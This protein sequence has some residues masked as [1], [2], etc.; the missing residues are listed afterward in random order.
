[1]LLSAPS[2]DLVRA[3]A[4][5][6]GASGRRDAEELAMDLRA[7]G[8]TVDTCHLQQVLEQ[9]DGVFMRIGD[10]FT[11][12]PRGAE[13]PAAPEISREDLHARL[14]RKLRASWWK[15]LAVRSAY[16]PLAEEPTSA[17]A[18][19]LE[20]DRRNRTFRVAKVHDGRY[21]WLLAWLDEVTVPRRESLP[22]WSCWHVPTL[23][24]WEPGQNPVQPRYQGL[25]P[26]EVAVVH[27]AADAAAMADVL[28]RALE[29]TRARPQDVWI[30]PV[31]VDGAELDVR[32]RVLAESARPWEPATGRRAAQ[33]LCYWCRSPLTT[34]EDVGRGADAACW[35]VHEPF[36]SAALRFTR[37]E[38]VGAIDRPEWQ[39]LVADP[40]RG[41][42]P[43]LSRGRVEGVGSS[44]G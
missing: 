11:L 14:T 8:W 21:V 28:L 18:K 24:S 7:R 27:P 42:A 6:L 19:T 5:L 36:E 20:R 1:M 30:E 44:T 43:G 41:G 13:P 22:S 2:H 29:S 3:C 38:W 16:P 17:L 25:P 37:Q 26:N 23:A 34:N 4:A 12:L 15:V 10:S 40:P 33:P 35:A 32:G 39:A 9:A 31:P